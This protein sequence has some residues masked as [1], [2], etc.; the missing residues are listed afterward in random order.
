[1]KP[2]PRRSMTDALRTVEL[3]PEAVA[4][5]REGTPAPQARTSALAL[6]TPVSTMKPNEAPVT[7]TARSDLVELNDPLPEKSE[8]LEKPRAERPS[9]KPSKPVR[10]KEPEL[11]PLN[12]QMTLSVRLP[13]EIPLKI[14][15]AATDR[16][17]ARLRPWTQQEIVAEALTLWL[18]KN[19]YDN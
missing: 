8:P 7:E 4:L 11:I 2:E 12:T 14:L 13:S 18:R 3:T 16:K 10:E 19:G 9:S 17:I 6:A 1:M 5:I 15:R